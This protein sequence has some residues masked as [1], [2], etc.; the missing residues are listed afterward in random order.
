MRYF[1]AF[2]FLGLGQQFIQ[3]LGAQIG[4]GHHDFRMLSRLDKLVCRFNM[5]IVQNV[6]STNRKPHVFDFHCDIHLSA[7]WATG[8]C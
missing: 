4:L 3:R 8:N 1:T 5:L 7:K 2:Q 6:D